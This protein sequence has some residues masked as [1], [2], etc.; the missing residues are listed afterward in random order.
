MTADNT[1]D[2]DTARTLPFSRQAVFDAFADP[3]QLALWWG[4]DGFS[5]VIHRFDFHPGGAP[6]RS[7]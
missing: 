6:G 3:R 7:P 4:P 2:I 1:L 5:N